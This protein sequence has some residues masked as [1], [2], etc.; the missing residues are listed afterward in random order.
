MSMI[1]KVELGSVMRVTTGEEDWTMEGQRE[2]LVTTHK[3]IDLKQSWLAQRFF[4]ARTEPFQY[5]IIYMVNASTSS[6]PW[7]TTAFSLEMYYE[8]IQKICTNSHRK[9]RFY[10]RC[11][12]ISLPVHGLLPLLICNCGNLGR[13]SRS[14]PSPPSRR[15]VKTLRFMAVLQMFGHR[16]PRCVLRHRSY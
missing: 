3:T 13:S 2:I 8:S 11:I 5:P 15:P 14:M 12:C 6:I 4:H 16:S 10:V 9:S 7:E 1:W